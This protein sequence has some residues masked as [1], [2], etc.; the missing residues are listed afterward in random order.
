MTSTYL[1]NPPLTT[2]EQ[3]MLAA[4][5]MLEAVYA[6]DN[7]AIW[8]EVRSLINE[9]QYAGIARPNP[10]PTR[11]EVLRALKDLATYAMVL[12]MPQNAPSFRTAAN[13]I[14]RMEGREQ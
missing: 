9:C 8:Q 3:R 5:T 6:D 14:A 2:R 11:G 7:S 12:G 10:E 1:L 13:V 4:L